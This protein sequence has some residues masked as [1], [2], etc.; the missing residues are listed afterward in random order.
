MVII[1]LQQNF[2]NMLQKCYHH[3]LLFLMGHFAVNWCDW[4]G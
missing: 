4:V 3:F 2:D 1:V